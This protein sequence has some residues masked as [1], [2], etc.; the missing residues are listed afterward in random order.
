MVTAL[1]EARETQTL[2]R[3]QKQLEPL[4]GETMGKLWKLWVR[5]SFLTGESPILSLQNLP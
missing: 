5:Q 3:S 4:D 1:L 2:Q